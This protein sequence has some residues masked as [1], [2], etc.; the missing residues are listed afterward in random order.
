MTLADT[1]A[2]HPARSTFDFPELMRA[3]EATRRCSTLCTVCA[4]SEL[5][6]G[7]TSMH[8]CIRTCLDCAAVCDATAKVLSRPTPG[9]DVWQAQVRA[10]IL[11][12]VECA[13]QCS[14]HDHVSCAACAEACRECE[15]ALQQLV[16][17]ATE[18]G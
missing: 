9:G 12:C 11:A 8:D 10:C 16:A 3:I 6:R 7:A 5:A 18:S 2:D 17:A 4:D 15:R 13:A 14:Q 1:L